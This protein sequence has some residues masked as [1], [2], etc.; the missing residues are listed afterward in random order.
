MARRLRTLTNQEKTNME[1]EALH[2]LFHLAD[3]DHS[4]EVDS[5]ELAGILRALSWKVTVTTAHA[6]VE[7]IA[8]VPNSHGLFLLSEKQ[9]LDAML[10]GRM[11]SMLE[12]M[13]EVSSIF[14]HKSSSKRM[15]RV[16]SKLIKKRN[17]LSNRDL[18]IKWT[19]RKNIVAS[20]LSG[21]TQLLMLSHTPVSRKVF[22][23]FDCNEMAG[24]HYLRADY[25]ID[26]KSD[27]YLAFMP[28]VLIVLIGFTI[29]LPGVISFYLWKYRKDLYST[30]IYQTI[31]WLYEPFVRGAE[32]WLVH[33]VIM[34]M[35]LT[36][37]L[38]YIPSAS[39]AG[40][41]TLVCVIAV[42][43]L[44][45]FE[46]HK[47]K[48]IFWLTQISFI[49][50]TAKYVVASLLL[51]DTENLEKKEQK[52]I[53]VLLIALDVFFLISSVLAILISICV[54]RFRMKQIQ[55]ENGDETDTHADEVHD[56]THIVPVDA[57]GNVLVEK[58]DDTDD[59]GDGDNDNTELEQEP[60]ERSRFTLGHTRSTV[61]T[62]EALHNEFQ[63]H[64][65]AL[66]TEQDKRQQK[67][68]R[69]TQNRVQARLK[70][71]KN[72]ALSKVPMF[73]KLSAEAIETILEATTYKKVQKNIVLCTEGDV[74][75]EFYII[76]SGQCT[77][78]VGSGEVKRKVGTLRELDFFGENGLI[79]GDGKRNATVTTNSEY[80]QV[81][82]L[83]RVNFNMLVK[84]GALTLDVVSA[85]KSEGE[86][87][88]E[89]TRQSQ[90]AVE[91]SSSM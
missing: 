82:I 68:R 89:M 43:N 48:V 16:T 75:R 61:M 66:Q 42:A 85:V 5:A 18:L 11:K 35:I 74:A 87:R 72:K 90:V 22:Q 63:E 23:Y 10:S 32:F 40:V 15:S 88:E 31:G 28:A 27:Q 3:A 26:C 64:E 24:K 53:G 47:N 17:M 69:K 45:Y 79:E 65:L 73:K 30:T 62:A 14:F 46:P 13:D 67:Q 58:E 80:V 19:L 70:V 20:S 29:A 56:Q 83:S 34:K 50:T 71:R 91:S 78:H 54:L 4:G 1:E 2:S 86:R 52:A 8:I 41:A 44:N 6:V 59:E 57:S 21:A 7:Q 33:D 49:T 12:E 25:D 60:I 76:V 37:T 77:V 55:K 39:R 36:G 38:I 51:I 84:S 9:F 81:L